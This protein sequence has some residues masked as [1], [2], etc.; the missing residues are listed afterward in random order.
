MRP[1]G[2]NHTLELGLLV[3]TV[4][5]QAFKIYCKA[6]ILI[7][8]VSVLCDLIREGGGGERTNLFIPINISINPKPCGYINVRCRAA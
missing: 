5:L 1:G 4:L 7:I 8:G 3:S 6:R 2:A